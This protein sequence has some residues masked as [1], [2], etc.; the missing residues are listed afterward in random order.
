VRQVRQRIGGEMAGSV[1]LSTVAFFLNTLSQK[2][3]RYY[4]L[5]LEV[6]L[7][8]FNT[9]WQEHFWHNWPSYY[10][11]ATIDHVGDVLWDTVYTSAESETTVKTDSHVLILS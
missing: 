2:P 10:N 1:L 11:Q 7:T 8:D 3:P 4:R 5:Q 9:V 6:G